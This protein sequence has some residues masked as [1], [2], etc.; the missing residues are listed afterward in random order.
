MTSK[1]DNKLKRILLPTKKQFEKYI[2][3]INKAEAGLRLLCHKCETEVTPANLS[4][5]RSCPKECG[6]NPNL[7]LSTA[8]AWYVANGIEDAM[9]HIVDLNDVHIEIKDWDARYVKEAVDSV[10]KI[11]TDRLTTTYAIRNAASCHEK[12]KHL[13]NLLAEARRSLGDLNQTLRDRQYEYSVALRKIEREAERKLEA[14]SKQH[15]TSG[16]EESA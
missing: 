10:T 6:C 12:D 4:K 9:E 5:V 16:T 11:I 8:L 7:D 1:E 14:E 15:A 2:A 3:D 13:F